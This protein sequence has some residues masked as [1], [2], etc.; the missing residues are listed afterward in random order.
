[1]RTARSGSLLLLVTLVIVAFNQRVPITNIPPIIENIAQDLSLTSAQAGLLTSIPVLCFALM[2]PF[3]SMIIGRVGTHKAIYVALA[4]VLTGQI[5]R[6]TGYFAVALVGTVMIGCGIAVGNV[7]IPLIIARDFRKHSAAVTGAYSASMNSMSAVATLVSVPMASAW[8]WRWAT[9]SWGLLAI[10]AAIMWRR[11]NTG[12]QAT[13]G[14][15]RVAGT[16]ESGPGADGDGTASASASPTKPQLPADRHTNQ[17]TS[18][19]ALRTAPHLGKRF[20]LL[21]ALLCI[22]FA[23]Q[24]AAYYAATAWLPTIVHARLGLDPAAAAGMS[25]PFQLLAVVGALA[26]PFALSRRARY[27]AVSIAISAFWLSLPLG[28][29]FAPGQLWIWVILAG[30]A[31]GGN[32]TLIFTLIAHRAPSLAA[33]RR[34]SAIMQTFAYTCAAIAPTALGAL[35]SATAGWNAPLAAIAAMLA[36]MAAVMILASRTTVPQAQETVSF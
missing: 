22:G 23:M 20:G 3:A 26:M 7:S 9:V 17:H 4:L 13:A 28:L 21:T 1:M 12:A 6:P 14:D 2:T 27:W 35:S 8:G 10:V 18:H 36:I 5:V 24:S 15:S 29:L 31:Q 32:Y 11:A 19:Q 25:A 16:S 34:S 30:I 33:A